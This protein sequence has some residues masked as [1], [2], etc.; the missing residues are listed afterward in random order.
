MIIVFI[1]FVNR[2]SVTARISRTVNDDES[3]IDTIY[4]VI[5]HEFLKW[6]RNSE[7]AEKNKFRISHAQRREYKTFLTDSTKKGTTSKLRN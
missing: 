7:N 4:T 5:E 3:L 2:R 1:T 6:L